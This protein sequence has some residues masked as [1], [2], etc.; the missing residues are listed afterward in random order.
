[1]LRTHDRGGCAVLTAG[2]L[3]LFAACK[4]DQGGGET[5]GVSTSNGS[6]GSTAATDTPAS[7]DDTSA[8]DTSSDPGCEADEE[9]MVCVEAGPFWMGCNQALDENCSAT[10]YPYHEV[11]LDR[12]DIDIHEV[13]V[14]QYRACVESD[15]CSE[16]DPC[17]FV[18][19]GAD[20]Q[21]INCV[22][23]EQARTYCAW[24]G[25]RLPTEA[26]W[27]KAARGPDERTF[28]WGEEPADCERAVIAEDGDG[29]GQDSTHAVGSRPA[30]ASPY[31]ALDMIG[32]VEEWV[33][34]WF[35]SAY[36]SESPEANPEGPE[37]G[38]HRVVR[39][40]TFRSSDLR[41]VRSAWRWGQAPTS[42]YEAGGFRCVKNDLP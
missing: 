5:L 1:M 12:F 40:G 42:R 8:E 20:D 24:V 7:T 38:T 37:A 9:G 22:D 27:E 11:V 30:G 2:L 25:K 31:G 19:P 23:W 13:T 34:D 41:T 10:E 17:N 35:D 6:T 32:N 15:A 14:A 33:L 29:C 4:E 16:P 39:G 21:P 26:Q 18:R 36:Y 28:P 3:L